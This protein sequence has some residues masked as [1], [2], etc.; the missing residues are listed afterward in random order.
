MRWNWTGTFSLNDGKADGTGSI[1]DS[2]T[3]EGGQLAAAEYSNHR[4][5]NAKPKLP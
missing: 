4:L 1:V 5:L 2:S 3:V